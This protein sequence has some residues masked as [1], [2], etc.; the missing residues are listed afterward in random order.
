MPNLISKRVLQKWEDLV[1]AALRAEEPKGSFVGEEYGLGYES[2]A[3]SAAVPESLS[4]QTNIDSV[5]RVADEIHPENP[6]VAR[7]CE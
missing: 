3:S 1:R 5:L 2:S 6:Q 4:H 7:I